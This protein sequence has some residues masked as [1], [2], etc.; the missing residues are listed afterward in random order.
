MR[1]VL[2]FVGTAELSRRKYHMLATSKLKASW[3]SFSFRAKRD[4]RAWEGAASL[5]RL[6]DG[7]H[8][9]CTAEMEQ[10]A[11]VGGDGLVVAGAEAE[12]GAELVIAS[13]E[14]RGGA[15]IL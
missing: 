5:R 10:S 14:P 4:G 9:S 7:E 3:G 12:E 13:T 11:A 15:E 8:S 1:L 6:Q 2:P